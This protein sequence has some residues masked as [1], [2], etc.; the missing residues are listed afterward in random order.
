MPQMNVRSVLAPP[1]FPAEGRLPKNI[2]LVQAN[3]DLQ[4]REEKEFKL[5]KVRTSP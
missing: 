1:Y 5:R 2:D 4:T 3:V